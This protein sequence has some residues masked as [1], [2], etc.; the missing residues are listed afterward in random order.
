ML[1]ELPRILKLFHRVLFITLDR[2]TC[3]KR[4][5]TRVYDPPDEPGYFDQVVW[6]SYQS[7]LEN[8]LAMARDDARLAFLDGR[9][10]P[11][12]EMIAENLRFAFPTLSVFSSTRCRCKKQRD[13]WA[14][15][16]VGAYPCL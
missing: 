10:E 6:P 9:E 3:Q 12:F 8:A 7:H 11:T 1:T 2:D 5:S 4:R 14:F 13:L 16:A 15:Q